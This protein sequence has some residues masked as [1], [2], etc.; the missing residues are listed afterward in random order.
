MICLLLALKI[1]HPSMVTLLRG[2]HE[3]AQVDFALSP[4]LSPTL[5]D[6]EFPVRCP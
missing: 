3:D 2:N 5:S 6:E 1:C 4:A